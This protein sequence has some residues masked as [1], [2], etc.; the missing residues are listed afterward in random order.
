MRTV[1]EV[2]QGIRR[3]T[4]EHKA[5]DLPALVQELE[6]SV[7]MEPQLSAENVAAIGDLLR[8]DAFLA[9]SESWRLVRFIEG[10]W[11]AVPQTDREDLR[12]VMVRAFDKHADWMGAFVVSEVLGRRYGDAAALDSLVRL[13]RSAAM[14]ARSL[15]PHGLEVMALEGKGAKERASAL[16]E[17]RA[18]SRSD[19]EE[20]RSEALSAVARIEKNL[21]RTP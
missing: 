4:Q 1:S 15:V 2:L 10:N 3:S 17:L 16:D 14:P 8:A 7:L 11:E 21:G 19:V 5:D 9:L 20:V 13:G 18:L 12:A 6:L